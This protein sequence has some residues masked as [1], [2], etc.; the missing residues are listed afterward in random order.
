MI[1]DFVYYVVVLMCCDTCMNSD[2]SNT[3]LLYNY[4]LHT[5]VTLLIVGICVLHMKENKV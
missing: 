4:Y 2:F 1:I 5:G 3:K